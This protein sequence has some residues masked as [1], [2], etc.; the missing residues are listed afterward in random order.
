MCANDSSHT[1]KEIGKMQLVAANGS[2]F[3]LLDVLFVP[4]IKK[5]LLSVSALARN[6]LVVKFCG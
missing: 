2:I 4:G 1:I 6:G 3:V 5:N